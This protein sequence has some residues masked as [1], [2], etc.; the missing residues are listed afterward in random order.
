MHDV[1]HVVLYS[2]NY[3][4]HTKLAASNTLICLKLSIF[5]CL[6]LYFSPV[7][8]MRLNPNFRRGCKEVFCMSALK[9]YRSNIYTITN[10]S[11][12]A[13]KNH[14]GV[15]SDGN[16]CLT[17]SPSRTFNRSSR[18]Q[19]TLWPMDYAAGATYT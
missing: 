19:G 2:K 10:T 1:L 6:T 17:H 9:C 4:V 18:V 13:K 12:V 8:Y 14:I 15:T 11:T 7:L 16:S 5:A 3:C